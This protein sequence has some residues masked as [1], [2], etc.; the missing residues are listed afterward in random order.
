MR[1]DA[2][3]DERR[4]PDFPLSDFLFMA[5]VRY[6]NSCCVSRTIKTGHGAALDNP[7]GRAADAK[8]FP[9]GVSMCCNHDKIDIKSLAASTIHAGEFP[10]AAWTA[11]P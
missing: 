4:S 5:V 8:V 1:F 9:S 7:F 10:F 6:T 11:S 2:I 3:R